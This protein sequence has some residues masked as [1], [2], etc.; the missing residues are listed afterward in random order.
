MRHAHLSRWTILGDRVA[1][2]RR[3]DR[4][5]QTHAPFGD[6]PGAE[7][8][9]QMTARFTARAVRVGQTKRV[10]ESG[11]IELILI[12][13]NIRAAA[14]LDFTE[15]RLDTRAAGCDAALSKTLSVA[16]RVARGITA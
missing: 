9:V 6:L 7:G 13:T 12:N 1:R 4:R 5:H 2:R 11:R 10:T 15:R 16:A 3:H 14:G 8:I